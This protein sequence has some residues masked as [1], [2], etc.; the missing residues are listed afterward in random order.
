LLGRDI[1]EH[2]ARHNGVR[3]LCDTS[4]GILP[5]TAFHIDGE[6][7][8]L[9]GVGGL[10]QLVL[11]RPIEGT[12]G[13]GFVQ[14]THATIG[15]QLLLGIGIVGL[16]HL[17]VEELYIATAIGLHLQTVEHLVRTHETIALACGIFDVSLGEIVVETRQHLVDVLSQ[18]IEG[19]LMDDVEILGYLGDEE[20]RRVEAVTR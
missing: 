16:P 18:G 15:S 3:I 5:A 20:R 8:A 2:L 13:L 12:R 17:V 14:I 19:E 4:L 9:S 7:L 6:L 1:D 10:Q 11:Q